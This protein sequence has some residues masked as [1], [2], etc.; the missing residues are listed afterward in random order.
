MID[1]GYLGVMVPARIAR[2]A[3]LMDAGYEQ[4]QITVTLRAYLK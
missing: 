2:R 4:T 1:V 3:S